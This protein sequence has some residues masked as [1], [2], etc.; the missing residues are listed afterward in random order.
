M[1]SCR[2]TRAG[3]GIMG[4]IYERDVVMALNVEKEKTRGTYLIRSIRDT[5]VEIR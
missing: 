2:M 5:N 1:G 3:Q 4:Q